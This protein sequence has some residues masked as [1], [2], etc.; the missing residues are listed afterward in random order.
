MTGRQF[1]F[2]SRE[3]LDDITFDNPTSAF[4]E[5]I[6][7]TGHSSNPE[8]FVIFHFED[9]ER[10]RF[11]LKGPEIIDENYII[12]SRVLPD[13]ASFL[14]PAYRITDTMIQPDFS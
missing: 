3:H 1:A 5:H 13:E 14:S 11:A 8:D 10:K 4:V 12:L 6:N 2:R 9:A 7:M